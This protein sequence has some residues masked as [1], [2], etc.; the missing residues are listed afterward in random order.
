MLPSPRRDDALHGTMPR[1]IDALRKA[2]Y[3][4]PL[5]VGALA[6]GEPS[7]ILPLLHFALLGSS[8]A[9]ATWLADAGSGLSPAM[10]DARFI[11]A[12]HR[13]LREQFGYRPPLTVQQILGAGFAERKMSIALETL[14]LCRAKHT[15]LVGPA[16]RPR[17]ARPETA[18]AVAS[19]RTQPSC[20]RTS[21]VVISSELR[22]KPPTPM[23]MMASSMAAMEPL[24]RP[25][26]KPPRPLKIG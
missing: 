4:G 19:P 10:S 13:A 17:S 12:A 9:V 14:R 26:S 22:M 25:R 8:Q 23:G 16:R 3:A 5:D 20:T 6:A 11:A 7:G 2:R 1:L 24:P 21:A 15:E 18:A